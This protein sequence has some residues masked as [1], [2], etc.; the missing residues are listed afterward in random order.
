MTVIPLQ[1][2]PSDCDSL[3]HVN[4]SAYVAYVQHAVAER[5]AG[6]GLAA[7]WSESGP[8]RWVMQDLAIEYRLASSFGDRLAAQIWLAEAETIRPM[9]GCEIT[10]LN[11]DDRQVVVRSQSRWQRLEAGSGQPVSLPDALL[12]ALAEKAGNRPRPFRAPGDSDGVRRYRWQ[13]RAERAE[14]GLAGLA[15]PHVI[16][17][18]I[19]ESVLCASATAGWPIER[20]LASDFV[21]FQMRHDASFFSQPTLGQALEITNRLVD[22]RRLRGTWQNEV[23]DAAD[24]RLIVNNYSTGVFLNLAGRPTSPPPGMME[25]LQTP[26]ESESA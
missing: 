3:D 20:C 19:E 26:L 5:L 25:A 11:G 10:R 17:E 24:G 12:A 21:V 1:I 6:Q 16:F 18:W 2:R 23:R 4:N 7:D 15:H 8:C 14:V 9:F 13:H 22:V